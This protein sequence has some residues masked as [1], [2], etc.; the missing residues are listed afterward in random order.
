MRNEVSE[1]PYGD[2]YSF[3]YDL[4]G[5]YN[6]ILSFLDRDRVNVAIQ[7][8]GFVGSAMLAA[9]VST[10]TNK[11]EPRY[12]VIGVD[13][14][15]K[16]N[17]WKIA[18]VE[19]GKPP[20]KST[21]AKLDKAFEHGKSVGNM[22]A[23]YHNFA[24]SVSDI[25]VVDVHLDVHKQEIGNAS[26]YD[27]SYSA[28]EKAL[29][30]VAENCKEDVLVIIE[31]TVPPGTTENVV[32]PLFE[33]VYKER[34]L[35]FS[36][37]KLAH[38]YE[39]VMPG[40]GYLDSITNFYRVFSAIGSKS[41]DATRKFLESFINTKDYPLSELASPTASEM[42]KVLE[43]SYRAMNIAFISEWGRYAEDAGVNL[44][45]VIDAIRVRPT[46]KNIMWPGFGVG[47]YCLTKDSLLADWSMKNLFGNSEGLT[48]TLQAI[49]INDLMPRDTV[50]LIK[51]TVGVLSGKN[52][53]L[54]GISYL[55]DVADTRYSPSYLFSK[56][57]ME[58]GANMIFHDPLV[59]LWEEMGVRVITDFSE[60]S[61]KKHEVVVFAV[62][63]SDYLKLSVQQ[64]IEYFPGASLFVDAF[65]IIDDTKASELNQKGKVVVGIGKGNFN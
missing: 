22:M 37:F 52:I 62:R 20:V 59:E 1:S 18:R 33:R 28:Y 17:Y 54:M 5:E 6:R 60:L 25:I 63:H 39:R 14:G 55:N 45:E 19:E 34:G 11:N 65:N 10:E 38:S 32:W 36:K 16:D 29:L 41:R 53:T 40:P 31:T 23:T 4:E 42:A 44:Y 49:E 47:G 24:Y 8:L 3:C 21:D 27:F 58:E 30:Q 64:L 46:H 26:A 2:K 15:D 51:D 61:N 43:N 57:C 9:L 12:N 56:I 13:L 50:R 48:T 7:G 35:D